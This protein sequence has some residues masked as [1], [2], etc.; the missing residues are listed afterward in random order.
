[1]TTANSRAREHLMR[2]YRTSGLFPQPWTPQDNDLLEMLMEA[3]KLYKEEV[4]QC[5]WWNEYLYVVEIDGMIIGYVYAAANRDESVD[6]LGY[7]FDPST[8]C[9]MRSVE[10]IITVYEATPDEN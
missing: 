8:I 5:R 4:D 2:F 10:K 9:E 1:M 7:E 6:E 3:R